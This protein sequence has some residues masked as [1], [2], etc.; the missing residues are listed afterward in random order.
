LELAGVALSAGLSLPAPRVLVAP[1]R[2]E[3]TPELHQLEEEWYFDADTSSRLAEEYL[4]RSASVLLG[5][6]TVARDGA[7][8]SKRRLLIDR[9][10]GLI[11]RL[12]RWGVPA[13]VIADLRRPV[14]RSRYG[15][16][17]VVLADPPWHL[18]DMLVWLAQASRLCRTGGTIAMPLFGELTKPSAPRER[19]SILRA[20]EAI[21]PTYLQPTAVRYRTPRFE[22]EACLASGLSAP[23]DWRVADL[24]IINPRAGRQLPAVGPP[25]AV[26]ERWRTWILGEQ[27]V[28]LRENTADSGPALGPLAGAINWVLPS[29]RRRHPDRAQIGLWTSRQRVATV[30]DTASVARWLDQLAG[31]GGGSGEHP[32]AEL[33]ALI[34]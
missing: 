34:A 21:G 23:V 27:V 31:I 30:G 3:E 19:A 29:V 1:P 32:P 7:R 17:M 20:A 26:S 25:P 11:S 16:F 6:P 9:S 22:T 28:K 10:V 14:A 8:M 18:Q 12:R 33:L 4:G 15:E 24:L 5:C 13:G 2:D